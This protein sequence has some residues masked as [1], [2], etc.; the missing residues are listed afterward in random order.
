MELTVQPM[1]ELLS[2]EWEALVQGNQTAW[3]F[4]ISIMDLAD[5]F[6][7]LEPPIIKS[8]I[9]LYR[10]LK[11]GANP[12][13]RVYLQTASLFVNLSEQQSPEESKLAFASIVRNAR[14]FDAIL[15]EEGGESLCRSMDSF[16]LAVP[17]EA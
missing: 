15:T 9:D 16:R 10:K 4:V 7:R 8:T 14:A 6:K 3:Q 5:E 13:L 11:A 12:H 1:E 17:P 2:N